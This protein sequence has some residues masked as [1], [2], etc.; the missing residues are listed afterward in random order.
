MPHGHC[1]LWRPDILWIHVLSDAIIFLAYMLIPITLLVL[2]FRRHH[3]P[4]KWI[5]LMFSLFITFCGISHLMEIITIWIPIY[6]WAG[7]VKAATA[8]VSIATAILFIPLVP[9]AIHYILESEDGFK[10]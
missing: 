5:L 2:L 4:N 9:K 3:L 8:A 7:I 10:K 6:G 1:F